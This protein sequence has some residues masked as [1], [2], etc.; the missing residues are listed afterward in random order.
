MSI[1]LAL[2][3]EQNKDQQQA[4]TS[5]RS[6]AASAKSA[7]QTPQMSLSSQKQQEE[8]WYK[9]DYPTLGEAL[10]RIKTH[11]EPDSQDQIDRY[12]ELRILQNKPSSP[13]YSP[14]L[15]AT[16][17]NTVS[18]FAEYGVD[19]SRID[20]DWLKQYSVFLNYLPTTAS[21]AAAS[22]SNKYT[23]EQ[24]IA[25]LYNGLLKQ[26]AITKK[27]E[28][29]WAAVKD[30]VRYWTSRADLNMSDEDILNSIDWSKYPT[31]KN[32]DEQA[33]MGT[34]VQLTRGIMYDKDLLRGVIYETRNNG[35]MGDIRV[36]T[37]YYYGG[38]GNQYVEDKAVRDR[39]TYGADTYNPYVVSGT[40]ND[41]GLYFGQASFDDKWLTANASIMNGNDET[42]KKNYKRVQSAV[43]TT[44]KAN[45][46]LEEFNSQIDRLIDAGHS[47]EAITN[48]VD[49]M[50]AGG[51][52]STLQKLN[53]TRLSGQ[54]VD[55]ASAIAFDVNDIKN[56]I[57]NRVNQRNERDSAAGVDVVAQQNYVDGKSL[58]SQYGDIGEK[59]F[60]EYMGEMSFEEAIVDTWMS[61]GIDEGITD[62]AILAAYNGVEESFARLYGF[63]DQQANI[64][65][66]WARYQ[67]MVGERNAA[68]RAIEES[69]YYQALVAAGY[70]GSVEEWDAVNE[71]LADNRNLFGD[72][73]YDALKELYTNYNNAALDNSISG[74]VAWMEKYLADKNAL[75]ELGRRL[76]I[77]PEQTLSAAQ[78]RDSDYNIALYN[79][80]TVDKWT[81]ELTKQYPDAT[82][83]QLSSAIATAL[84]DE[85][86]RIQKDIAQLERSNY[87]GN[88][89]E[90][91]KNKI[92]ANERLLKDLEYYNLSENADYKLK[93]EEGAQK[94]EVMPRDREGYTIQPTIGKD[95]KVYVAEEL[96]SRMNDVEKERY[97]YLLTTDPEKAVDYIDF[98][99]NDTYGVIPHRE[100]VEA[101]EA[102]QDFAGKNWFTAILAGA[103]RVLASPLQLAGTAY[104][105]YQ[106][107]TGQEINPN[108]AWNAPTNFIGAVDEQIMSNIDEFTGENKALNFILK[109]VYSAATSL[110]ESLL[111]GMAGP[112]GLPAMVAANTNSTIK[113]AIERGATVGEAI[114]LGAATALVE[115]GTEKLPFD[116]LQ[117]AFKGGKAVAENAKKSF[118]DEMLKAFGRSAVSGTEDAFGEMLSEV[119]GNAFDVMIMGDASNRENAILAEMQANGGDRAAAEQKVYEDEWLDVLMAGFSGYISSATGVTFGNISSLISDYKH[120]PS[121]YKKASENLQAQ[122]PVTPVAT[123]KSKSVNRQS[124]GV[125]NNA[126]K[127]LRLGAAA[128]SGKNGTA[129]LVASLKT[130]ADTTDTVAQAMGLELQKLFGGKAVG[131]MRDVFTSAYEAGISDQ[132]IV[133][134]INKHLANTFE[135]GKEALQNLAKNVNADTVKKWVDEN[136]W[137]A[138]AFGFEQAKQI[139]IERRLGNIL[140]AG[141]YND[142]MHVARM[143]ENDARV[144]F[145]EAE[146]EY[147]AVQN[148]QKAAQAE[149]NSAYSVY[150]QAM[151]GAD[152]NAF[153]AAEHAYFNSI[154]DLANYNSALEA[155]AQRRLKAK[156]S[157]EQASKAYKKISQQI[158]EKARKQATDE[159]NAEQAEISKKIESEVTGGAID[160]AKQESKA[161]NGQPQIADKESLI[162]QT[163][164][165]M[166]EYGLLDGLKEIE[167]SIAELN[168]KIEANRTNPKLRRPLQKMRADAVK[169]YNKVKVD[170][171][172][173][174]AQEVEI[175]TAVATNGE[176]NPEMVERAQQGVPKQSIKDGSVGIPTQQTTATEANPDMVAGAQNG[177]PKKSIKDGTE[178]T[179]VQQ[180]QLPPA[181]FKVPTVYTTPNDLVKAT[182]MGDQ[183]GTAPEDQGAQPNNIPNGIPK[184]INMDEQGGNV[185]AQTGE[186]GNRQGG[187]KIGVPSELT[188]RSEKGDL[189]GNAPA[190]TANEKAQRSNIP[191]EL[192]KNRN[193]DDATGAVSTQQEAT[194][195][196]QKSN[197]PSELNKNVTKGDL[198]G[199]ATTQQETNKQQPQ[200]TPNEIKKAVEK[201]ELPGNVATQQETPIQ[202]QNENPNNI[203]PADIAN[204]GGL[205]N[206]TQV[207]TIEF[208]GKIPPAANENTMPVPADIFNGKPYISGTEQEQIQQNGGYTNKQRAVMEVTRKATY[209]E[210]LQRMYDPQ[211]PV[212]Q[213]VDYNTALEKYGPFEP[214]EPPHKKE[215]AVPK[216]VSD[217]VNTMRAA[218]TIQEAFGEEELP[219][220][221][222]A[223]LV[224]SGVLTYTPTSNA[225]QI[226]YGNGKIRTKGYAGALVEWENAVNSGRI[227]DGNEMALGETL[228][229]TAIRQNDMVTARGLIAQIAEAGTRAGQAVQAMRILKKLGGNTGLYYFV[230]TED[231]LN[232]RLASKGK[233]VKLND[234]LLEQ[235]KN[236]K[237]EEE[238]DAIEKAIIEDLAAQMPRTLNDKM[239]ALRYLSMM[240][241]SA[242]HVRNFAGNIPQIGQVLVKDMV[243]AAIDRYFRPVEKRTHSAVIKSEYLSFAKEYA[244]KRAEE[245]KGSRYEIGVD[246]VMKARKPFDSKLLNKMSDNISKLLEKGDSVFKSLY[247]PR[248]LAGYLQA[249]KINL[250]NVS[251]ETLEKAHQYA[252]QQTKEHVYQDDNKL[253]RDTNAYLREHPVLGTAVNV[254]VPFPKTTINIA[255]RVVEYS[256]V[257]G[258]ANTLWQAKKNGWDSAE[259]VDAIAKGATGGV[260]A[261]LGAFLRSAGYLTASLGDEPED[262]MKKLQGYQEY[263]LNI[264]DVSYTIGWAGPAA[265]ELMFGAQLAEALEGEVGF[266]DIL[267]L[268]L[269]VLEPLVENSFLDGIVDLMNVGQYAE[270][271]VGPLG[272]V[273]AQIG[274]SYLQQ[275]YP[276]ALGSLARILDDTR[277]STVTD[278]N[279]PLPESLQY[280]F[281]KLLNKIP[282][283]SMTR[284]AW[285]DEFGQ[286]DTA[287]GLFTRVV[288]NLLSPGYVNELKKDDPVL[289]AINLAYI[290]TNDAGVLPESADRS[291]TESGA[292]HKLNAEQ[293]AR[294]NEERGKIQREILEGLVSSSE[295]KNIDPLVQAEMIKDVYKYASNAARV[296][297]VTISPF[298]ED[299][300]YNAYRKGNAVQAILER[301]PQY[302]KTALGDFYAKEL[303][304]FAIGGSFEDAEKR[305]M[306]MTAMYPFGAGLS[307]TEMKRKVGSQLKTQ[308]QSGEADMSDEEYNAVI[309]LYKMGFLSDDA[310]ID[311]MSDARN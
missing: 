170:I 287:D 134:T 6:V 276:A 169:E 189:A 124:A 227:P 251:A 162:K 4:A 22:T 308:I 132:R 57:A 64:E 283:F 51:N 275:F 161:D 138:D 199:T 38:Q 183:S 152:H 92:A 190:Q 250:S 177:V 280:Q 180:N 49:A 2:E 141:T 301:A 260:V 262:K 172:A 263:A 181:Q 98:L 291:F 144:A 85:N 119:L 290:L 33:A 256:V 303:V 103:G 91:K 11:Y 94:I 21:G 139:H 35:G 115:Y 87:S 200:N 266:D 12:E 296:D 234:A 120:N 75:D 201:G 14:Y 17:R 117:S 90:K 30:E 246:A 232:R 160:S 62:E 110:G 127:A 208:D 42:A 222:I 32:L 252:L 285:T 218:R 237:T 253:V 13:F 306:A 137:R 53:S 192:N 202:P 268:S 154:D 293:Y 217:T 179:P 145:E 193:M 187:Q 265:V 271:K 212:M 216:K 155:T 150:K 99:T 210:Q 302:A 107:A 235:Y 226:A 292:R 151:E 305:S 109:G 66:N 184:A 286:T 130:K 239:N 281:A 73:E 88:A 122:L 167:T 228:L 277:R 48:Y 243:G 168:R 41:L 45:A 273:G 279:S 224:S 304:H 158:V 156:E 229:T 249:K 164:A 123:P 128:L 27:A 70:G 101:Q 133:T 221:E 65:A 204:L 244:K 295:W 20:D 121:A 198:S 231:Q 67:E 270:G 214:G 80:Y 105:L 175:L 269:D 186:E 104:S 149:M 257:G 58:I 108:S 211:S 261:L 196:R 297:Y 79:G 7:T 245:M 182:L 159:F 60:F 233:S 213:Q 102:Y 278:P 146:K 116:K 282:G 197:I 71:F 54:L 294:V 97:C 247:Y 46:E 28:T 205:G 74:D 93:A 147:A 126:V 3:K 23:P 241:S 311:I 24:N 157:Y 140:A 1:R 106:G 26:E 136:F 236:A 299:W 272:E 112:A 114:V 148:H 76:G 248:I 44:N 37:A 81:E 52:Y 55:T 300:Q 153:V 254:I 84:K 19:A 143:Q 188:K 31:L 309:N 142:Q 163:Y 25:I 18:R 111:F 86:E 95:G 173:L 125:Q 29:E 219:A 298:S 9:D 165:A 240:S 8:K 131:F 264:G 220:A 82:Q 50:I 209:G 259:V 83:Q 68:I 238:R 118:I 113:N 185:V 63:N 284:P 223:N 258:V 206:G 267:G 47:A 191:S 289:T 203:K 96:W 194:E 10:W 77:D 288:E 16:N 166:D 176:Y 15:N 36:D 72:E 43:E 310:Y 56:D 242:T 39:L 135:G 195:K 225:K 59:A 5:S 69:P 100:A 178:G 230:K 215:A 34:P 89:I 274:A 255:K 174:V 129:E 307:S 78:E 207:K 61:L 171:E 40:I